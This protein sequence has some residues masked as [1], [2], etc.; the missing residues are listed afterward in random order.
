MIISITTTNTLIPKKYTIQKQAK[1]QEINGYQKA[2]MVDLVILVLVTQTSEMGLA[3]VAMI[4]VVQIILIVATDSEAVTD[5]AVAQATAATISEVKVAAL[6]TIISEVDEKF[7][8]HR[9]QL[10]LAEKVSKFSF[11]T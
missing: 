4:L 9:K 8:L 3:E 11:Y 10:Q 6:N 1:I 5:L 7:K 2:L